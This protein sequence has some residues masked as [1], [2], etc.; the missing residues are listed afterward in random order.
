MQSPA[1]VPTITYCRIQPGSQIG[2]QGDLVHDGNSVVVLEP[3]QPSSR[4]DVSHVIE[5]GASDE[6]SC[7]VA[8]GHLAGG[9]L[10]TVL[11][12]I[13]AFV[14][15]CVNVVI[16]LTGSRQTRKWS[17][18]KRVLLPFVSNEILANLDA[19]SRE[20]P[21]G[22]Y[23]AQLA[24]SAFDVQDEV[25]SD[26][27]RPANR[28][29]GLSTTLEDGVAVMGLHREKILDEAT[30]R[31]LLFDACDNRGVHQLPVGGS[32]DT[33]TAVF[34]FRLHQSETAYAA[35]G[36][37]PGGLAPN[38]QVRE[39]YS[40]FIVV[41][42]QASDPLAGAQAGQQLSLLAGANLFRSL[43][44]FADVARKLGNAYRAQ[45]A[46]FRASKLTYFLSELL[47]GNALVVGLG[48]A[49]PGEPAV[50]RATL[51][52]LVAL[53]AAM[54]F[55]L[56]AR[57]QSDVLRGLLTKYRALLRHA[58]DV[59]EEG[60]SQGDE[61][62]TQAAQ[63][64]QTI[65]ALQREVAQHVIERDKLT[66][67]VALLR[68]KNETVMAEKLAQSGALAAAEEDNVALAQT[69]VQLQ[70]ALAQQQEQSDARIHDLEARGAQLEGERD[71]LQAALHERTQQVA[72]AEAELRAQSDAAA[73]LRESL[74]EYRQRCE[75]LVAQ[76]QG[77]ELK[78]TELSAEL[79]S[80]VNRADALDAAT[81][82]AQRQLAQQTD[83]LDAL[84]QR[85]AAWQAEQRALLERVVEKD[86]E[87]LALQR[88][89]LGRQSEQ[90]AQAAEKD[91]QAAKEREQRAR[92]AAQQLQHLVDEKHVQTL[93]RKLQALETQLQRQAADLQ[94]AATQ[95]AARDEEAQRLLEQQRQTLA[96]RL[97]A[98][99][100]QPE[101]AA[102]D[103]AATA[104]QELLQAHRA[105]EAALRQAL[106]QETLA[107]QR[108][109][110]AYRA[111]FDQFRAAVEQFEQL[112][113]HFAALH[114]ELQ[115]LVA[116]QDAGA[117]PKGRRQKHA[118]LAASDS[119]ASLQSTLA[120][121]DGQ[122]QQ[123]LLQGQSLLAEQFA[124]LAT[125]TP[126]ASAAGAAVRDDARAA[127]E[128]EPEE[129]QQRTA[130]L[131]AAYQ[132]KL[133]QSEA[134][135]AHWQRESVALQEQV[136]ALLRRLSGAGAG[137]GD[138]ASDA[139]AASVAR[140][141]AS[142]QASAQVES[143][144]AEVRDLR[145]QL[146]GSQQQRS[147]LEAFAQLLDRRAPP[148]QSPL[149]G[150]TVA[151]DA[152]VGAPQ[153]PLSRPPSA[154][155]AGG[156][157]RPSARPEPDAAV[158]PPELPAQSPQPPTT[159][160]PPLQPPSQLPPPTQTQTQT[161]QALQRD[162]QA[163]QA[164]NLELSS[165][166]TQLAEELRS[167]QAYMRD[168]LPQYQRKLVAL[169]QRLQRQAAPT[170]GKKERDAAP[171]KLP[172]IA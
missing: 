111:L 13:A 25:V 143:L 26:L 145:R 142:A 18:L 55:P 12:P 53:G 132:A 54:H 67:L 43:V 32:V 97:C 52:L 27:L 137:V 72:A 155:V 122:L 23:R 123:A 115:P 166:A 129:V 136:G 163:A 3:G 16:V 40:R 38:V 49:A 33:S 63:A 61:A 121:A 162:L 45:L 89:L 126:P 41:D 78:Q 81:R 19:K 58:Q 77:L 4:Y 101:D 85:E 108:A 84:Q 57:E 47:G 168:V 46:P 119:G 2:G 29:L 24:L 120:D 7:E 30:L 83:A 114:R 128:P 140:V 95:L 31:K 10:G 150:E 98:P 76:T 8:F 96:Q 5:R 37:Q 161:Q 9:G 151:V 91:A 71:G 172:P 110:A 42:L 64:A 11:N 139:D 125:Q 134:R 14:N 6:E 156:S 68:A 153:R 66:E 20:L 48:V 135:A 160:P 113:R 90:D 36:P 74:G 130:A 1:G 51:E 141:E 73:A 116:A 65:A 104:L 100:A 169:Q 88:R 159:Q 80:Q 171:D 124:F 22:S 28:G 93:Q 148:M 92:G 50:S 59:L 87:L 105:R 103:D 154:A 56:A 102:G 158:S 21:P 165:R 75:D 117:A 99:D 39:S 106:A 109:V 133:R 138:A 147:Q 94:H 79:L 82:E 146:L 112:Q 167:Y 44:A 70:L 127:A 164:R 157:R 131:L 152:P 118:T 34:E 35:G 144:V 62:A 107:R 15:D 69:I 86:D 149:D 170:G 60:E 17:Y